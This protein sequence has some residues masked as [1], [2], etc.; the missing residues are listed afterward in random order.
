MRI[1]VCALAALAVSGSSY[2]AVL[3]STG[4]E[5][6]PAT[7]AWNVGN[8]TGQNTWQNFNTAAGHTVQA[9]GVLV[10]TQAVTAATGSRM[11]RSVTS[12]S[13]LNS[14]REQWVDL[15][16]A[17]NAR[18]AGEDTV[19]ASLDIFL[20]SAQ[21][22][23]AHLHGFTIY[24][25]A[26]SILARVLVN[27]AT[28]QI[29]L[30][31][32]PTAGSTGGGLIPLSEVTLPRDRWFNLALEVDVTTRAIRTYYNNS[33]TPLSVTGTFS[34][35]SLGNLGDVDLTNIYTGTAGGGAGTVFTDNYLVSTLVTVPAPG[36]L[37]VLASAGLLAA[38]RRRSR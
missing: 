34:P 25:S 29:S 31:V 24:N 30:V 1:H 14:L 16:P 12:T 10:G 13:T 15:G 35:T 22:T 27:N 11:H 36:T 7:P 32:D 28:Q 4:W 33:T 8:I 20:P 38:R 26:A 19:R 17:F 6:S 2:G 37:G 18:P 3:Y 23:I 9:S 5:A 21:S